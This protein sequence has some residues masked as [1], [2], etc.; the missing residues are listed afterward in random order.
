MSGRTLA[1]LMRRDLRRHGWRLA[2][3]ALLVA[4]VVAVLAGRT[5][6]R[7]TIL[8]TQAAAFDRLAAA[9]LEIR[10][11]PGH[12]E[13]LREAAAAA[14]VAESEVRLLAAGVLRVE[15]RRPLPCI[16]RIL[17]EDAAPRMQR[18]EL[19]AGRM[20]RPGEVAAVIDRALGPLLDLAIGDTVEVTVADEARQVPVVGVS[21]SC[22]YPIAPIHPH[23][24]LPLRGTVGA[25]A[26]SHEA[27]RDHEHAHRA[28]SI[29]LRLRPGQS[30]DLVCDAVADSGVSILRCT[31]AA[32]Q[33]GR[34]YLTRLI[35]N[36]DVFS[37]VVVGGLG[38][39]GA[40]LAFLLMGRLVRRER[41]RVG[42][43]A[44][45][46]FDRAQLVLSF[47]GLAVPTALAGTALGF[48]AHAWVARALVHGT[49]AH[50]GFLPIED[51]GA[52]FHMLWSGAACLVVLTLAVLLPAATLTRL[53]PAR[54]LAPGRFEL[55]RAPG[56]LILHAAGPPPRAARGPA[57]V[58]QGGTPAPRPRP[59]TSP[60]NPHPVANGSRL[61]RNWNR[62]WRN[63]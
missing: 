38:V 63:G 7:A 14:D 23:Y 51:A 17:P 6:A 1:T 19:V 10:C 58:G 37:P 3:L 50:L 43:L 49:T 30:A 35:A 36:F 21:L 8:G 34:L 18:L 55:A 40:F 59:P 32:R 42:I 45:Q 12:I 39:A 46:G 47:L 53:S 48:A 29:L 54:A 31:P 33:P 52:D 26:L 9:D 62:I 28:T 13:T 11:F 22:E 57:G 25:I 16:V 20:P 60:G 56:G 41:V 5:R 2:A 61:W 44:I 27:A 15:G 4:A 24:V